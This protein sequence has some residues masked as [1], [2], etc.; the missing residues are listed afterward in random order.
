LEELN[1]PLKIKEQKI[2][3]FFE[4]DIEEYYKKKQI[5]KEKKNNSKKI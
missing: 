2:I 5:E 1:R 4:N 3:E